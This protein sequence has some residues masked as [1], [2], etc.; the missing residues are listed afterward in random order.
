MNR[1]DILL[2]QNKDAYQWVDNLISDIAIERWD[3]TPTGID[4]NVNWQIGHL[5]LSYYFHTVMVIK[6]HDP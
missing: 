5:L 1:V 3:D 6:G 2:Q 4:T